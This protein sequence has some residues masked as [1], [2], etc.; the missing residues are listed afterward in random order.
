MKAHCYVPVAAVTWLL[1]LLLTGCAT[2]DFAPVLNRSLDDTNID[3]SRYR[4]PS[5]RSGD[6]L[7]MLSFSGGGTRAAAMAYGVLQGLRDSKVPGP[8]EDRALV[9]EVDYISSV[10]GGSFT[11]AY[12]G[13]FGRKLFT[14]FERV[15]L[16]KDI[17]AQVR[18]R[19]LSFETLRHLQSSRYGI[20]DTLAAY[21]DEHIFQ[22][23]SLA[24][25][26]VAGGPVVDINAVD[27]S[28][29]TLFSFSK[30]QLRIICADPASI[31]VAR[32]V[33]ASSAVPV[34]FSAVAL[35]NN[36]PECNLPVPAWIEETLRH[37]DADPRRT[38]EADRIISYLRPGKRRYIHLLDGGLVD[39]L[40][41]RASLA[42]S[43]AAGGLEQALAQRRMTSTRTIVF[44][45]V[46]A[47]NWPPVSMDETLEHPP[48]ESI[49]S[50]ATSAPLVQYN[51]ETLALLRR[52]FN[53]WEAGDAARRAYLIHLTFDQLPPGER[54]SM[55]A[56]P[57]SLSLP[58]DQVDQVIRAGK[59]LLF[60]H[61]LFQKWIKNDS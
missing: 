56:M 49:I 32:A 53:D 40:G 23:K 9:D 38:D 60:S 37:P 24:D 2:V 55:L 6:L 8:G 42:R 20:S 25:L 57:T 45:V 10:S 47:A 61:P 4:I 39:N 30:N 48:L 59:N 11:A 58:P 54:E 17:E 31:P 5:R 15:F 12:F 51:K 16:R 1:V 50:A 3:F 14:D 46:D 18:R 29:G 21:Y 22:G 27:I 36:A 28:R 35:K 43:I 41:V 13:L 19:L 34:L 52:H 7:L 44:I 33:A 26:F